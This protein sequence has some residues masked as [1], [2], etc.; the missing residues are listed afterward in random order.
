M[1]KKARE[2]QGLGLRFF[3]RVT[4][5][6]AVV[7]VVRVGFFAGFASLIEQLSDFAV[8]AFHVDGFSIVFQSTRSGPMGAMGQARRLVDGQNARFEGK[9]G[10]A[11]AF[12]G[13]SPAMSRKAHKGKIK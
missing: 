7:F 11:A 1:G 9:M 12:M 8:A 13:G 4:V 5:V 6:V 3:V 10:R 2:P